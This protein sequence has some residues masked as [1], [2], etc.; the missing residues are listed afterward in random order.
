MEEQTRQRDT[1]NRHTDH[2]SVGVGLSLALERAEQD[3]MGFK[4]PD[5]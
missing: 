3:E 2:L 1:V 4:M 5:V